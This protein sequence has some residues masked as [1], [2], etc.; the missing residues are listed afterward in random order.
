MV[1]DGHRERLRNRFLASPSSFED[2]ELLELML[3]Y[4]VPRKNT[5]ELAH[6]LLE[7]FGSLKCVLDA[8]IPALK[9][10]KDM[11]DNSALFI[12][13]IAEVLLRYERCDYETTDSFSSYALLGKYMRSLFVGTENE[14]TYLILLDNANR[15]LSCKKI[16]EGYSC[17]NTISYREIS[18]E[19][20]LQ[21]AAAA[22]LVH[23]HPNGKPI[24]SGEDITATAKIKEI[25]T[26][27]GVTFIDHFIVAKGKCMPI[28]S[29]EK[30]PLYNQ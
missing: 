15:L 11:G 26:A 28:L 9:S 19:A 25:L 17:G 23:N 13:V 2:H 8:G 22:I 21:N 3:F 14:I 27:L 30:A 6:A 1:H 10:V 24:P 20:V 16:A 18:V 7:R 29:C 5:N 4:V 12:R